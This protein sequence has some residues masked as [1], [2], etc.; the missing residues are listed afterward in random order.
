MFDLFLLIV[1]VGALVLAGIGVHKAF[2]LIAAH[3]RG[4]PAAGKAL[5]DHLFLPLFGDKASSKREPPDE[6]VVVP[7]PP[8]ADPPPEGVSIRQV[9]TKR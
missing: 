3:I 6:S 2:G 7:E 5:Y 9:R 8:P 1:V 4:H